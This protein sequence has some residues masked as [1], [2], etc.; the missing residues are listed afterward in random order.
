MKEQLE[1]IYNEAAEA[2]AGGDDE[3]S[4]RITLSALMAELKKLLN[5]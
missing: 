1:K 5:K 2:I 3:A 4:V